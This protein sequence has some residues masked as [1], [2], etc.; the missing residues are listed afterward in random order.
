MGI[1]KKVALFY[2]K[3]FE[4]FDDDPASRLQRCSGKS[5]D[6]VS[7]QLTIIGSLFDD[8]EII[9]FTENG[10]HFEELPG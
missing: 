4:W 3:R 10:P 8:G 9:W 7:C 1:R 5:H 2:S 6:H